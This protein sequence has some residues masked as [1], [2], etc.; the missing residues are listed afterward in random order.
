M[1]KTISHY[2]PAL[3]QQLADLSDQRKRKDYSVAELATAGIAMFLLKQGSR[4]AMNLDR[5]EEQFGDNYYKVFKQRLPQMDAVEKLFRELKEEELSQLKVALIN[6]LLEKKVLHKF[7]VLGRSFNISVDAT[8]VAT[9]SKDYCGKCVFKNVGEGKK[10]YFHYV[11]EAKLVT[12]SGLCL[13]ICSEWVSNT[14]AEYDKQD[15]ELKAFARL[16][17]K[18][19]KTFPRLPICITADGLY[20]NATF[21]EICQNN[22]WDFILT[23]KDGNLP[24][25]WKEVQLL[26]ELQSDKTVQK[27]AKKANMTTFSYQWRT[28]IEYQKYKLN[29]IECRR[30][31]VDIQ[32]GEVTRNRFVHLT[33]LPLNTQNAPEVS[34]AGRMRWK[35][36][37]EGFNTQK[38]HGY[39]LGHKFSRVSFLAL[40]NYYQCMQIAHII[41]QLILHSTTVVDLFA[42]DGKLTAKHLWKNLIGFLKFAQVDPDELESLQKRRCQ[43]RLV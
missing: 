11:L 28:E 24:S 14:G 20:P 23:F 30:E 36:E 8:H 29:W 10:L 17:R 3:Y 7:K 12:S 16:A 37:N 43:I 34:R 41:N 4:N 19:K 42:T 1:G 13:S 22:R 32:T 31:K 26:P 40:K 27:I 6:Q 15:C 21:F 2:F 9:Y 5:K 38:N 25:V 39:N 33:N 18:L 35:I